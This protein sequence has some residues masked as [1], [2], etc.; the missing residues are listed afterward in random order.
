MQQQEA[1]FNAEETG[2]KN[3]RLHCRS[4]NW[5]IRISHSKKYHT[6]PRL[7]LLNRDS[8][9]QVTRNGDMQSHRGRHITFFVEIKK[10]QHPHLA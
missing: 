4:S 2:G 5:K 10:G 1:R 6:A 8:R 9:R 3:G 7:L